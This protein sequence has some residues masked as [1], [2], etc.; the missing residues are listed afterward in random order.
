[1]D[2]KRLLKYKKLLLL[3]KKGEYEKVIREVD[4]MFGWR[5]LNRKFTKEEAEWCLKQIH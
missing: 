1:M 5:D 4:S 3:Y 2:I